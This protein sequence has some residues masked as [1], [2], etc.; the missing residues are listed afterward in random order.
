MMVCTVV[1]AGTNGSTMLQDCPLIFWALIIFSGKQ[2]TISYIIP[3]RISKEWM[4][5][6][7]QDLYSV[8]AKHKNII[9]SIA[10]S[11]GISGLPIL[12]FTYGGS[13]LQIIRSIS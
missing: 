5:I 10:T 6:S 1:S 13:S 2:N 3:I 11:I 9:R 4:M 7:K 12:Y 8:F